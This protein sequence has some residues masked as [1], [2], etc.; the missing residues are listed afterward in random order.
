MT[1]DTEP[2]S[3]HKDGRHACLLSKC[4]NHI[5]ENHVQHPDLEMLVQ[6]SLRTASYAEAPA[7]LSLHHSSAC[8]GTEVRAGSHG[9]VRKLVQY[10]MGSDV[11]EIALA[12][13]SELQ[14]LVSRRIR[15]QHL[16]LGH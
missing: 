13:R 10:L 3:T 14:G 2:Q 9:K 1:I 12:A 4:G 11:R 8:V 15:F 16:S 5:A 6:V 7:G